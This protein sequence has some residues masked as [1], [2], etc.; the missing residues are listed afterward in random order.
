MANLMHNAAL[1]VERNYLLP[2]LLH[3]TPL[4]HSTHKTCK[5]NMPALIKTNKAGQVP[6]S[7]SSS[8]WLEREPDSP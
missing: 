2:L 7:T 3:L 8:S 5:Q 1:V 6:L 4:G